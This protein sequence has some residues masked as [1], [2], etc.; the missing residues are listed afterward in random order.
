LPRMTIRDILPLVSKPARYLG[1]EL[2][3]IHKDLKGVKLKFA[4]AFPDVYEIGM[5]H[6]GL[7][8]LYHIL[9]S[10]E[11]IA[12][13]RVFAPWVDLEHQ[14]RVNKIPLTSLESATPLSQFDIV[15]FSLQSELTY[16]NVLNMLHLAGIPLLSRERGEEHPLIIA[17]GP[18]TFNPEP[19]A[20]FLDAIVIGEGEEVILEISDVYIDWKMS[21]GSKKD[22][23]LQLSRLEGLYIPSFFKVAYEPDG[24][25][26]EIL[27][28]VEGYYW[29]KRRIIKDINNV[30]FPTKPIVPFVR[31]VHDR[32]NV[33]ICR[34]C[35]R[36][37]RFCQ[38]G[39]IYRP[40]R[41]R[42]QREILRI[43]D[44]SLG[45]SGYE[46]ISLLS[47]STG[48][49]SCINELVKSLMSIYASTNLAISL[50]SL[51]IGTITPTLIREICRV[52]K[53]GFTI[54]PEAGTQR[55]RD[56]INKDISEDEMIET[57]KNM[58]DAGWNLIKLYFM[59]G[60]PTETLEDVQAIGSLSERILM[61]S[62]R[63]RNVNI[64]ISTFVPKAHTPFQWE[65]QITL[66]ESRKRMALIKRA[67]KKRRL[68]IKWNSPHL[69]WL[70]GVFARGDRRLGSVLLMAH[71]LGCHFDGWSDQMRSDRWREAFSQAKIDPEF[72]LTR[73]RDFSEVLPWDHIHTGVDKD[74]FIRE[75][76]K[77]LEGKTTLDCRFYEC[78]Q[79]G[80]CEPPIMEPILSKEKEHAQVWE[81]AASPK[82]QGMPRRYRLVFSKRGE[83]RYFSHLD[84]VNIFIRALRRADIPIN[85]SQG[86]HPL[87]KISFGTAL[88][89]G[90]ESLEEYLDIE[91][92]KPFLPSILVKEINQHLPEGL[93]ILRT[94]QIPLASSFPKSDETDYLIILDTGLMKPERLVEFKKCHEF[95]IDL[96]K[97]KVTR[98]IDLK[99]VISDI[100]LKN[101][102]TLKLTIR[103]YIPPKDIIKGIFGLTD[104]DIAFARIVKGKQ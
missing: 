38:A 30:S 67:L 1:T 27:P 25:I 62:G 31:I 78:H 75:Y 56:V 37:C 59:I 49:Y 104:R 15:G 87:P 46:D 18:C 94:Y 52:R 69:S 100:Q 73:K 43:V 55:L 5:S 57:A 85:Y 24:K 92:L 89:L 9:N 84:M 82:P 93:E 63:P 79:C 72:F 51:R 68:H 20:D 28:L 71:T 36:G 48:D 23:L 6:L 45:N 95:L 26:K 12:A 99:P 86:F 54:A 44:K 47:L 7:Q 33:E 13:E 11:D 77:S 2:N 41:E 34:G 97:N 4:L 50:P 17:G 21:G 29:V 76:E 88:P 16:T 40:V 91:I 98:R 8:I 81:K 64:S 90:M 83:A 32:L 10:R 60:L 103:G 102:H 58:Y 53:T 65:A 80:V 70:E 74:F 42:T 96:K 66:Q 19:V 14:M 39:I 101:T 22:L 35:T 61:S 3:S